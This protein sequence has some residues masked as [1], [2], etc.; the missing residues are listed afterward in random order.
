MEREVILVSPLMV[1]KIPSRSEVAW[2]SMISE[3]ALFQLKVTVIDREALEGFNLN[4]TLG[5]SSNPRIVKT[6]KRVIM[7]NDEN[8]KAKG[9]Y[10]FIDLVPDCDPEAKRFPVIFDFMR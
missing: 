2:P 6:M 1:E 8:L 3:E 5:T 9:N 7:V 4:G 10:M